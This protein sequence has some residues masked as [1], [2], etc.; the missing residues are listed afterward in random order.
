LL[1]VVTVCAWFVAELES[2][3]EALARTAPAESVTVPAN[4][5]LV[6]DW[7]RPMDGANSSSIPRSPWTRMRKIGL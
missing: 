4:P 7:H 6:A 1:A 3:M 5:P 2:V